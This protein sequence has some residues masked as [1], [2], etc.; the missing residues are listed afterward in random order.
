MVTG[1]K[2][3]LDE[4]A[5]VVPN[6]QEDLPTSIEEDF[7][8]WLAE[9]NAHQETARAERQERQATV[10]AQEA[11]A[12]QDQ[13]R[14]RRQLLAPARRDQEF[15][16][17]S[18]RNTSTERPQE[19]LFE[20]PMTELAVRFGHR[21]GWNPDFPKSHVLGRIHLPLECEETLPPFKLFT[22]MRFRKPA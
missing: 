4:F 7:N 1:H 3:I 21:L 17:L 6:F 18:W 22:L 20:T 16:P 5:L 19:L 11:K 14:K 15:T 2:R 8:T 10:R 12:K 9:R 13:D